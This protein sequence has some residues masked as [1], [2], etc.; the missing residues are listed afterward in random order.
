MYSLSSKKEYLA[1]TKNHLKRNISPI[2]GILDF[3][4]N[5]RF[6]LGF[7]DHRIPYISSPYRRVEI[8]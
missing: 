3:V 7:I 8:P 4:K 1:R 6:L 5:K 2:K